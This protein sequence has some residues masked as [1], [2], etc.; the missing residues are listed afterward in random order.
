ML[1]LCACT[2]FRALIAHPSFAR[3]HDVLEIGAGCGVCG[4]LAAKLGAN[5]VSE[6]VVSLC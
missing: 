6:A 2:V 4:I 1:H 3:G 5:R